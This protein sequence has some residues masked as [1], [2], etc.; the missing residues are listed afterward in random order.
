MLREGF[1]IVELLIVVVV[2]AILAAI[3]IVAYNGISQRS[4]VANLQSNL[5]QA[6]KKLGLYKV[7]N[8]DRYPPDITTAALSADSGSVYTYNPSGDTL[9]FCLQLT[10]WSMTYVISNLD[11]R[12]QLGSCSG[13][14]AVSG[15]PYVSGGVVSTFAGTIPATNGLVNANGTSA[16]FYNPRGVAVDPSGNVYV[17]DSNNNVIRKVSPTADATTF[18]GQATAGL[19]NGTGAAAQF[20]YPEVGIATD[21]SGNIYIGDYSNNA[22][23]KITP[24]GVVTTLAG[25]ATAGFLDGIGTAAKFNTPEGIGVDSN[26]NLYMADN[27]NNAIRKIT[28]AGVVTTFAGQA[29]AGYTDA[30]GTAAQFNRPFGVAVDSSNNVY[31]ADTNNNAIRKITQAGDVTTFAGQA[32]SGFVN[33]TGT[34]AK[35]WGLV[36]IAIDQWGTMYVADTGNEAIRKITPGGVVTTLAGQTSA[37]Y[38]NATGT[39]AQF[40]FP[41]GIAVD[42]NGYVYVAD[43]G[44]SCIRVIK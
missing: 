13:S 42:A 14:I 22:I 36:D 4:R 26:G 21:S 28:P 7:D 20:K 27:M 11:S 25:Q 34:A 9:S 35:F 2:I 38:T 41:R 31:V 5:E 10:N 39:A 8:N 24:A 29:T 32:T 1:T 23:R 18:A 15:T 17:N 33:A 30:N 40:W 6:G 44:N 19:V 37:G 3:T 16:K 43:T 12:P